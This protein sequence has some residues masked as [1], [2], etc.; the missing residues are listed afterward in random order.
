MEG[1][2]WQERE[3]E[4]ENERGGLRLFLRHTSHTPPST[5]Q[6]TSSS[7]SIYILILLPVRLPPSSYIMRGKLQT[8]LLSR[9]RRCT[10]SRLVVGRYP[11]LAA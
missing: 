2:S 3:R 4:R 5:L 1:K 11:I 10:A 7:S 6:S 9:S 8:A